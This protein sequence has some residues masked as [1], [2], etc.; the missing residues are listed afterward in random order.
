VH[1]EKRSYRH[2]MLPLLGRIVCL[3]IPAVLIAALVSVKYVGNG[4]SAQ[5]LPVDAHGHAL[6]P[7]DA[8]VTVVEFG[9][10]ECP[11]C[12]QAWPVVQGLR[13]EFAG[14]VRFVYR[15]WL[16]DAEIVHPHARKAAEATEC[17][18]EQGKFWEMHDQVLLNQTRL[19]LADLIEYGQ[20]IGLEM[21]S[22]RDCL[23]S[24]RMAAIVLRDSDE[25]KKH[26]VDGTPTFFVNGMRVVGLPALRATVSQVLIRG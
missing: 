21:Q 16:P 3:I 18:A 5:V 1:A 2:S 6:G 7:E 24:G 9:D 13:N 26:G 25:G 12:R 19:G 4:T 23:S 22:S 17:A 8:A 10:F 15:H 14:Q 11:H 20:E